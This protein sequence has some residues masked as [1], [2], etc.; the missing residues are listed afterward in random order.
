MAVT[1]QVNGGGRRSAA[2]RAFRRAICTRGKTRRNK[3]AEKRR[4]KRKGYIWKSTQHSH[5]TSGTRIRVP[6]IFVY[7]RGYLVLEFG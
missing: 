2:E 1:Q 6:E 4:E 3:N 5:S 7:W